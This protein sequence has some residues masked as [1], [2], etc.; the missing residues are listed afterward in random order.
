[1]PTGWKDPATKES[2]AQPELTN[3]RTMTEVVDVL[4]VG[5]GPV[6]QVLA[7]LLG[8]E[9]FSMTVIEKHVGLYSVS[10][11]GSLDHEAMRI[12]QR[13]G[14]AAELEPKLAPTLAMDLRDAEGQL[15]SSVPVPKNSISGWHG[16]YQLYQPDLE[17]ALDRRVRGIP[18]VELLTGWEVVRVDQHDDFVEL[19]S[20][21]RATG[22]TRID[23][24]RFLVGTDGANSFVRAAAGIQL[25]DF[26]YVGPWLV[27]DFE[28][29]DPMLPLPFYASFVMNPER[30]TLTGRWLGRR[31][32]RM[33]FMIRPDEDPDA[34]DSEEV[35]WELSRQYG[36][37]PETSRIV[38]HAV[39]K[40]RSLLAENWR[41][42]RT[43]LA[44][45]SAHVMPPFLGQGMCSGFRD[46]ASLA[47]RLSLV[48]RGEAEVELLDSY[49][50]ERR[51]H[52]E[53]VI[54]NAMAL[55][56]LVSITDPDDARERD[57]DLRDEGL[58]PTP[59][60]PWLT[61]GL[62]LSQS[63][64]ELSPGAGELSWQAPVAVDGH[65]GLLDDLTGWGWRIITQREID[66]DSLTAA[67]RDLLER[68]DIRIIRTSPIA[69]AAEVHD[70]E[71]EYDNWLTGLHAEAVVV[72]PDFYAYGSLGSVSEL[73]AALDQLRSQ[74]ELVA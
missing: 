68:L 27:C 66:L 28:H 1:M 32:S 4:Q 74:L 67:Q 38:R 21:E 73:G 63:N 14:I 59:P 11:A 9:G 17:D 10:R 35:C 18:G 40:F 69:G 8:S 42:G 58:P 44:G 23:R 48:L 50:E 29:T 39:Y 25:A 53:Q 54:R 56:W 45:D 20:R 47:W 13:V 65:R 3:D 16:A 64:G 60:F 33:E 24:G 26:G 70:V 55:G 62:L 37:V 46:A 43:L 51:D 49:T 61:S 12:L 57:T 6:G 41:S 15:V 22:Q 52:V 19:E 71:M 34:F 30:P 2:H 7:S 72:R 31:H 5:Y 36:L